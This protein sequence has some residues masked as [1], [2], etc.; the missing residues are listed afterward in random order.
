MKKIMFSL[1]LACCVL[2]ACN[3]KGNSEETATQDSKSTAASKEDVSYAVGMAL[4]QSVKG[5]GFDLDYNAFLKGFKETIESKKLK[6]TDEEASVIL[7]EAITTAMTKQAEENKVKETKFLEENKKKSGITT[8]E[9]G[10]QYE[11]I[12]EGTGEKP[13]ASD[14]V[15]VNYVGTFID[16][17]T[18]DS[19]IDRGEP[20]TFAVDQVIP[21][22]AEALQLMNVG[23]K[24]KFYIP[25]NLAYGE[26][27]AGNTIPP[28][29]PLIFEVE[30]L[31]IEKK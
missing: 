26:N 5:I 16:G 8:T 10:L 7:Q 3:A 30:L 9:S 23:S 14:T 17:N 13:A 11:V 6:F 31:G 25:S 20:A 15:T 19:S 29:T 24:Y 27:G 21:G 28:N 18:F 1:A 2:L 12:S 22:W 4:G